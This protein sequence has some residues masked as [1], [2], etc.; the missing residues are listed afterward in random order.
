MSG[1]TPVGELASDGRTIYTNCAAVDYAYDGSGNLITETLTQYGKTYIKT[2]TW[3]GAQ[4]VAESLWEPV[5]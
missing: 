3:S 2:Y 4:L 5:A 1:I